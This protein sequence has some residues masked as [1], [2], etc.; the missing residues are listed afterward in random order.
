MSAPT[1][2][3]SKISLISK[4]EIRY[5]GF[6]HFINADENTVGLKNVRMFGTEGRRNGIEEISA[7][8]QLY[9]FIIFR[10][11]DIKDLTVFEDAKNNLPQDPAI[12]NAK[13]SSQKVSDANKAGNQRSNQSNHQQQ[14]NQQQGGRRQG[15]TGGW[16]VNDSSHPANRGRSDNHQN[17]HQNHQQQR[18]N[19]N[20][21]HQGG[22]N[23]TRGGLDNRRGNDGGRGGR[24]GGRGGYSN[25]NDNDRRQNHHQQQRGGQQQQGGRGGQGG[26]KQQQPHQSGQQ[27]QQQQAGGNKRHF[28]V[29][30][31]VFTAEQARASGATKED[32]KGEFDFAA[33]KQDFE[34]QREQFKKEA[35]AKKDKEGDESK[36]EAKS[37]FF[38]NIS[39]D[40]TERLARGNNRRSNFREEREKQNAVDSET[41]GTE[42]VEK[43]NHNGGGRGGF[44][45]GGN[46]NRRFHRY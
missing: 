39:C 18:S 32:F 7:G 28:E 20:N 5:E 24:G 40:T 30:T 38:D 11:A 42:M 9:E 25:N 1:A 27:Q 23:N 13:A 16:N 41:F 33:A 14:N 15:S 8:D 37:S 35:Q 34:A 36:Y 31:G 17:Q 45:R 4:S 6:L 43:Q 10:G 2:V 3:G 12:L 44:R 21:Q 19:N 29:A 26:H 22:N 46:H